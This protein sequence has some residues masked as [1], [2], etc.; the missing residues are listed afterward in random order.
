MNQ[1]LIE[2]DG[3]W[4][5]SLTDSAAKGLLDVEHAGWESRLNTITEIFGG[6]SKPIIVD[7][8]TLQSGVEFDYLVRDLERLGVSAVII[9][10]KL[11]PK[12]DSLGAS[13]KQTLADSDEF[14]QKIER[15]KK[16]ALTSDFMIIASLECL[17]AG[18]LQMDSTQMI[19]QM[20]RWMLMEMDILT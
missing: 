15:G 4:G 20:V 2:F 8:D 9:E 3:F 5:S 10:D 19:S 1:E 17:I 18:K 14:A 6:T 13:A 7:G 12:G 16:A 11:L